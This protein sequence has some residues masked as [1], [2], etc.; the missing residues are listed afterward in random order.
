MYLA[1]PRNQ[2]AE[3]IHAG[4]TADP[5]WP[6]LADQIAAAERTGIDRADLR[7]I[8]TSRP[9]PIEQP[10]AALA[11]RLIDAIGERSTSPH[12]GP[13]KPVAPRPYE[14]PPVPTR[15]PDYARTAELTTSVHPG[16]RW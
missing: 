13:P 7:R 1:G 15:P 4:I 9:L 3:A 6:T 8:G 2:I 12:A 11:Y 14:P 10:A 16:P 5:H